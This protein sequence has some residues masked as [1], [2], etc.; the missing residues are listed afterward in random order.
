M[1][2]IV[3]S[4]WIGKGF[5]SS[6]SCPWPIEGIHWMNRLIEATHKVQ[7][8]CFPICQQVCTCL[9]P[10]S[11][12]GPVAQL[13][14]WH[15]WTSVGEV[16]CFFGLEPVPS[17][18]HLFLLEVSFTPVASKTICICMTPKFLLKSLINLV[19]F[20]RF[21]SQLPAWYLHLNVS[22]NFQSLHV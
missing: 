13:P 22:E 18:L 10:D 15:L 2:T 14:H 17:S 9:F 11:K 3:L 21:N 7:L 16:W 8:I 1:G 4:F 20:P 6:S 19:S 12:R 5:V